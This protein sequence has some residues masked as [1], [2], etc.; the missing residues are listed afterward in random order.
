MVDKTPALQDLAYLAQRLAGV[1]AL[2]PEIAKWNSI[3]QATR[4]AQAAK[5]AVDKV[6]KEARLELQAIQA[7]IALG[8]TDVVSKLDKAQNQADGIVG[9][10]T[11]AAAKILSD[12]TIQ[13]TKLLAEAQSAKDDLQVRLDQGAEHLKIIEAKIVAATAKHTEITNAIAAV[14]AKL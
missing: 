10:A 2:A 14:K 12:A 3:E 6:L 11:S 9:G 5:D 4:E 1:I 8:H 13:K 7:K